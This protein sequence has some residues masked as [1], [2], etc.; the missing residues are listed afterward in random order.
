MTPGHQS[1]KE[2]FMH[3]LDRH[4]PKQS[5][6]VMLEFRNDLLQDEEWRQRLIINMTDI[7]MAPDVWP[8]V[9]ASPSKS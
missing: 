7:L 1:G 5:T 6:K 9:A 4:T 3:S 8:A 2:G